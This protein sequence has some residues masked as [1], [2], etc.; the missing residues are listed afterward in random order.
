MKY[1]VLL[2]L[3]LCLWASTGKGEPR[4]CEERGFTTCKNACCG[5]NYTTNESVCCLEPNAVCCNRPELGEDST[6]F[7]CCPQG[8][9]ICDFTEGTCRPG[10]YKFPKQDADEIANNRL[11]QRDTYRARTR[12][13]RNS[14][15][16]ETFSH[17][18]HVLN[19]HL[20]RNVHNH[21]FNPAKKLQDCSKFR[22]QDLHSIQ[23]K[24]FKLRTPALDDLYQSRT[25]NRRLRP[26]PNSN[27]EDH[28]MIWKSELEVTK[29]TAGSQTHLA[30]IRD[31]R[32][33]ET[34]MWYIHQLN[35]ENQ[36]RVL[37]TIDSMPL[38]P[39]NKHFTSGDE[40]SEL[41]T[42]GLEEPAI[43]QIKSTYL[44]QVGCGVCH[45]VRP[46]EAASLPYDAKECPAEPAAERCM[47][48]HRLN[49]ND[50]SEYADQ[51]CCEGLTCWPIFLPPSDVAFGKHTTRCDPTWKVLGLQKP[52]DV[53]QDTKPIP[54]K[55]SSVPTLPSPNPP[56]FAA[57]W[58]A[59]GKYFNITEDPKSPDAFG[60]STFYFQEF[61]VGDRTSLRVDFGPVCPFKQLWDAGLEANYA[62]P[63]S[64]IFR[65]STVTYVYPASNISCVYCERN[66]FRAWHRDMLCTCQPTH[67][68]ASLDRLDGEKGVAADLWEFE[69]WWNIFLVFRNYR[70]VYFKPGTNIPLRFEEDL[71][72]GYVDLYNYTTY[73]SPGLD[74]SI[75]T[76][77]LQGT[78]KAYIAGFRQDT[79]ECLGPD[80]RAHVQ[81]NHHPAC[82]IFEPL[83][84][85]KAWYPEN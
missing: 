3:V 56:L 17:A 70:N 34:V 75:F 1:L 5:N 73:E 65:N 33:H 66:P 74:D 18:S 2:C 16:G 42:T 55:D 53:N 72:T 10:G 82:I 7:F 32:C 41:K 49:C 60:T 85:R 40:E 83:P 15:R 48:M 37:K 45:E 44:Q 14:Y 77:P 9:P 79:A 80:E 62:G 47:I 23:E 25:D 59:Q 71:D 6:R 19:G 46:G 61:G 43:Q 31:G 84:L 36:Q 4:T 64:V 68:Q 29:S 30:A 8:L 27:L 51:R 39:S 76:A 13:P 50:S 35:E 57:S 67:R 52:S 28:L 12:K 69:W 24:I 81:K 63:C 58:S 11:S 38:L 21:G 26:G 54:K 78:E 22:L 20:K